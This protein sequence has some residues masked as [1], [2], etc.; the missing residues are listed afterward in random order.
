[1][2]RVPPILRA[3]ALAF[4]LPLLTGALGC[5]VHTRESPTVS[6]SGHVRLD[7]QP[8]TR[9]WIEF[10]P[11]EGNIGQLRVAPV[12]AGG[13][14]HATRVPAGTVGIRFIPTRRLTPDN[15]NLAAPI[16]QLTNAYLIQRQ[17]PEAGATD[18]DIDL[19]DEA[20]RLIRLEVAPSRG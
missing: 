16:H 4:L 18:L 2:S 14:F 10:L 1:M 11:I 3:R 7:R 19:S 15:H 5:Q 8:I 12:G 13:A 6:V 17:I 20:F 9:G